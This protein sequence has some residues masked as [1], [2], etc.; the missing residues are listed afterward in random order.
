MFPCIGGGVFAALEQFFNCFNC[1]KFLPILAKF[2]SGKISLI[3][4][5]SL[6]PGKS[7]IKLVLNLKDWV[8]DHCY[9]Q[10]LAFNTIL[11]ICLS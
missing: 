7:K 10:A 1:K 11:Q 5:Y 8:T 6:I 3:C 9:D 2:A 4:E